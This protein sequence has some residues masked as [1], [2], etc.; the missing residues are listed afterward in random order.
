MQ[1]LLILLLG[2]TALAHP[3]VYPRVNGTSYTYPTSNTSYPVGTAIAKPGCN[4]TSVTSI[5]SSASAT[6]SFG[7]DY[8]FPTERLGPIPTLQPVIPDS[9]NLHDV[10]NLTPC[11]AGAGDSLHYLDQDG[12]GTYAIAT[13]KWTGPSVVLDHSAAIK[14]VVVSSGNL[15][16]Y[17]SNTEAF[18]HA[19]AQWGL[20]KDIIFVTFT[21]G[22]GK[23]DSA[24]RCYYQSTSITFSRGSLSA[25]VTGSS[26]G[27]HDVSEYVELQW[28]DYSP[29]YYAG[30]GVTVKPSSTYGA[31]TANPTSTSGAPTSTAKATGVPNCSAPNDASKYPFGT[32]HETMTDPLF[33]HQSTVFLRH[34]GATS[35]T[36][37]WTTAWAS[38]MS[39]TSTLRTSSQ[40]SHCKAMKSSQET[41]LSRVELFLPFSR[42]FWMG[43]NREPKQQDRRSVVL[44]RKSRPAPRTLSTKRRRHSMMESTH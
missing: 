29:G 31:V 3:H 4:S 21:P 32:N 41:V 13:P 14:R 23:F 27:I 35:S 7:G 28:G 42:R 16:I 36:V 12:A 43:P 17:F 38:M 30:G 26:K 6:A 40:P 25:V 39:V 19:L 20:A 34:A 15:V 24:E 18:E 10:N 11:K 22:C 2:G 44:P 8:E 37:R 33:F 9:V 5:S 1:L